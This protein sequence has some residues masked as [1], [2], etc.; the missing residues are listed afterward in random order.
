MP[1]SKVRFFIAVFELIRH[2]DTP[3][4]SWLEHKIQNK[5]TDCS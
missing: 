5:T 4:E 3:P 2:G 1:A